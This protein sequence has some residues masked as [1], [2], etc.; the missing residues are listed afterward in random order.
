MTDLE[1]QNARALLLSRA[2]VFVGFATVMLLAREA[3]AAS[4]GR[5]FRSIAF[6]TGD[7]YRYRRY[8][9]HSFG[10]GG[11]FGTIGLGIFYYLLSYWN[12]A[13]VPADGKGRLAQAEIEDWRTSSGEMFY[14]SGWATETRSL[15]CIE[16]PDGIRNDIVT[17]RLRAL[18]DEMARR[19]LRLDRVVLISMNGER[20]TSAKREHWLKFNRLGER[21]SFI[22]S[23]SNVAVQKMALRLPSRGTNRPSIALLDGRGRQLAVIDL[24]DLPI[25]ALAIK[26]VE[27]SQQAFREAAEDRERQSA[28]GHYEADFYDR[29]LDAMV[30]HSRR[31]ND[32]YYW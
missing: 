2:F 3:D 32:D 16:S 10:W 17:E 9:W 24:F 18:D 22:A 27:S 28:A 7:S 5:F 20:D 25:Q 6:A 29:S 15:C 12:E 30:E 26:L 14:F 23:S 4:A 21:W 13:K 31:S 8:S 11:F 1:K 19:G